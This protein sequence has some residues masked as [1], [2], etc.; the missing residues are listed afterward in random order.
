MYFYDLWSVQP[1]D[2]IVFNLSYIMQNEQNNLGIEHKNNC[3][4]RSKHL[5]E[6]S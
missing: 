1:G 6:F 3:L 2:G 5:V 4:G